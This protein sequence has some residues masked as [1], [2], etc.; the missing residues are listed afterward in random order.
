MESTSLNHSEQIHSLIQQFRFKDALTVLNQLLYSKPVNP[1]WYGYRTIIASEMHRKEE[2]ILLHRI[3][4]NIL[5][6]SSQ[7]LLAK[8]LLPGAEIEEAEHVL[9]FACEINPANPYLYYLL[10]KNYWMQSLLDQAVK[11]F[12]QC[13]TLDRYFVLALLLRADCYSRL[14]SH[15]NAFRDYHNSW[16]LSFSANRKHLRTCIAREFKAMVKIETNLKEKISE[17]DIDL[18]FSNF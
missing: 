9:Q 7:A 6:N 3:I 14:G 2:L 5:P 1:I 11:E 10:G 18:F 8:A 17:K 13:L 12:S 4:Q 16:C 15:T